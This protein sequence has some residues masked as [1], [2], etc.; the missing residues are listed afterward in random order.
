[1]H[2]LKRKLYANAR[3]ICQL[4]LT[5]IHNLRM[6]YIE[7]INVML[8]CHDS[9]KDGYESFNRDEWFYFS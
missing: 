8:V 1:M 6:L 4:D 3:T 5:Y 7:F 2:L 9:V